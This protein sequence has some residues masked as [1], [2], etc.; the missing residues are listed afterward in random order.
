MYFLAALVLV[1]ED[2]IVMSSAQDMTLTGS[3]GGWLNPFLCAPQDESTNL[4]QDL[5]DLDLL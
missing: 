3:L 1:C 4:L 5:L 2:V